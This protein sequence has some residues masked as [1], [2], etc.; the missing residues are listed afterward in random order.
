MLP[1]F[2]SIQATRS[3]DTGRRFSRPFGGAPTACKASLKRWSVSA[4]SKAVADTNAFSSSRAPAC[5]Q[6]LDELEPSGAADL[7]RRPYCHYQILT[8]SMGN[9]KQS[10]YL[11]FVDAKGGR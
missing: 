9:R 7:W 1:P 4:A 8:Q 11:R 5:F 6:P 3:D 2:F 10:G